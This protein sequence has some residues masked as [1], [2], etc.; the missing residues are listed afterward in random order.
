MSHKIWFW[1]QPFLKFTVILEAWIGQMYGDFDLNSAYWQIYFSD[2]FGLI[3][4]VINDYIDY[5][6]NKDS[7]WNKLKLDFWIVFSDFCKSPAVRIISRS[8]WIW[9]HQTLDQVVGKWR[10]HYMWHHHPDTE[11]KVQMEWF[12]SSCPSC[13]PWQLRQQRRLQLLRRHHRR[14]LL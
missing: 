4:S 2:S 12:T 10:H 1:I 13:R 11:Y 8:N 6:V 14:R 9:V 5:V 7:F 3:Y